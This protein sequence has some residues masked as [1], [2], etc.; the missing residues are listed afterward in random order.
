MLGFPPRTRVYIGE[1]WNKAGSLLK[2]KG[3]P[4]FYFNE[5]F[6]NGLFLFQ[7][8]VGR[9]RSA[10][11][12]GKS[13]LLIIQYCTSVSCPKTLRFFFLADFSMPKS[14]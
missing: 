8:I 12:S 14:S 1:T 10:Y 4:A 7:G 5:L 2:K 11:F 3:G 9:L 6:V 13:Q